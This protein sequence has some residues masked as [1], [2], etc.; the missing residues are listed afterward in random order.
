MMF[1]VGDIV[2]RYK[3]GHWGANGMGIDTDYEVIGVLPNGLYALKDY[4]MLVPEDY[5]TK[6]GVSSDRPS[7]TIQFYSF[8]MGSP[9][10]GYTASP[11][12][13]GHRHQGLLS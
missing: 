5:L 13:P 6:S 8:V 11:L 7:K 2:R 10:L 9:S 1:K 4:L 3:T 12:S